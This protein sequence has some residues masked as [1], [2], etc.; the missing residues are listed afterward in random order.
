MT[1]LSRKKADASSADAASLGRLLS[2]AAA[3][4]LAV[5]AAS[6]IALEGRASSRGPAV[7]I[8]ASSSIVN[9]CSG[10]GARPHVSLRAQGVAPTC[11][12]RYKWAVTGGRIVGEGQEVVWDFSGVEVDFSGAEVDVAGE[13]RS[14]NFYDAT[15]TVE[16]GASCGASHSVSPRVRVVAWSCP[17]GVGVNGSRV[18]APPAARCPNI[19]LCCHGAAPGLLVPFSATLSGGTPGVKPIFNWMLHGGAVASGRGTDSILVDA[20]KSAGKTVLATLEVDGYGPRCSA[21]CA[22]EVPTATPTPTPYVPTPTPTPHISKPTPT[23]YVPKPSPTPTPPPDPDVPITTTPTPTPDTDT[24]VTTTPSPTPSPCEKCKEPEQLTIWD[25]ASR[26]G[27]C[28][29]FLLLVILALCLAAYSQGKK[30][31]QPPPQPPPQQQPP[32]Y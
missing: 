3:T 9:V 12:A 19:N 14:K 22:T 6:L 7:S 26:L 24:P 29:P 11:G 10:G 23:P 28:W 18:A 13:R 27:L 1:S 2:I 5:A 31:S 20:K 16:G 8:I 30:K 4:V 25:A 17:P 21:S 32:P 15:L